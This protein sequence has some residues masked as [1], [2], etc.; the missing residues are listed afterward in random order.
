MKPSTSAT[1]LPLQ[2]TKQVLGERPFP[3]ETRPQILFNP[4]TR[5]PTFHSRPD[6]RAQSHDATML[7]SEFGGAREAN[8]TLEQLFMTPVLPW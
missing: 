5:R 1:P 3:I 8:G 7:T 6:G 4:D 2:L